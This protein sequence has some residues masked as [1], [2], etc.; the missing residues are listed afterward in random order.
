MASGGTKRKGQE[1][2][3]YGPGQRTRARIQPAAARCVQGT[4]CA[5]DAQRVQRRL[6]LRRVRR[7]AMGGVVWARVVGTGAKPKWQ[8][9]AGRERAAHRVFSL[10]SASFKGVTRR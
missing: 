8:Q 3:G 9:A 5:A 6:Q 7:R 4:S 1:T 2:S 10:N